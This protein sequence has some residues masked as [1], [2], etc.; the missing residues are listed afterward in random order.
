MLLW[1]VYPELDEPSGNT[2]ILARMSRFLDGDYQE[3][4]DLSQSVPPPKKT[5]GS[6]AAKQKRPRA[7]GTLL[8]CRLLQD[9]ASTDWQSFVGS[10]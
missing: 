1:S 4:W 3:L 8:E 5:M 6:V 10:V 2:V 7:G 9:N